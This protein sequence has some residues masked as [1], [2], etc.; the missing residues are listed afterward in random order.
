MAYTIKPL[1][2]TATSKDR[3]N[4]QGIKGTYNIAPNDAGGYTWF[5]PTYKCETGFE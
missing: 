4:A 2:W 3:H 1:Q 5:L